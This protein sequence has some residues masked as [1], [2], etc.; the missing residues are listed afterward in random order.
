ML[1]LLLH[2]KFRLRIIGEARLKNKAIDNQG[3]SS[4]DV[5]LV[6][7]SKKIGMSINVYAML[8]NL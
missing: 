4:D 8:S 6:M 5:R 3:L 7:F 2:E 1:I